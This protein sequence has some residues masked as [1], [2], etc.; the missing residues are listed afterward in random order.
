MKTG[1]L[2]RRWP[3]ERRKMIEV[4]ETMEGTK[5]PNRREGMR[6]YRNVRVRLEAISVI[7]LIIFVKLCRNSVMQ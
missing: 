6:I 3:V 1:G 2:L 7:G 5:K 4:E